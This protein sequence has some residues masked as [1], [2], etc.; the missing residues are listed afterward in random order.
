M[1]LI[2]VDQRA[3]IN[4]SCVPVAATFNVREDIVPP[5]NSSH[6]ANFFDI[7]ANIME[8]MFKRWRSYEL[9]LTIGSTILNH[10][11]ISL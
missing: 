11:D 10:I 5:S 7:L 3:L 4:A 9:S 8:Y 6:D 1:M 2:T